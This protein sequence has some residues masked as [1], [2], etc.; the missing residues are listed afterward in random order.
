VPD[1]DERDESPSQWWEF[2][3]FVLQI[4]QHSPDIWVQVYEDASFPR[5]SWNDMGFDV[6]ARRDDQ[7]LLVKI[8]TQTPQTDARLKDMA[9]QLVAAAVKYEKAARKL[10][11]RVLP[12][13][14]LP[15]TLDKESPDLHGLELLAIFPGVLSRSKTAIFQQ[16]GIEVWDGRYLRRQGRRLGIQV[17]SFVARPE[18]ESPGESVPAEAL[19][20]R[21]QQIQP[22]RVDA[23]AYEKWC[24]EA[25]QFLFCPPLKVP[26]A[27]SPNGSRSNRRDLILPNYATNGFFRFL[28]NHYGAAYIVA[29]MKNGGSR[30]GKNAVLQVSN[31]LSRHGT[32]L[33]GML[34]TRKGMDAS[35]AWTQRE[36]WVLHDKLII[37]LAD[38]DM[39]QMLLSKASG[40]SP[41]ETIQQKI[42]DFRL[43]I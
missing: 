3:Q 6:E 23:A 24:E 7:V 28:R 31:Y 10:S 5:R 37:C 20:S 2:E 38:E 30:A 4:L 11:D 12:D 36:N 40:K 26:I 8:K 13:F 17:P 41:A 27:Q 29:E 32:G 43:G 39:T 34:L 42:E 1:D 9:T 16:A 18:D 19:T 21:L 22:G 25:L 15:T 14:D 33:F 35:A